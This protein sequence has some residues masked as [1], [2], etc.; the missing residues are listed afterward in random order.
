VLRR[1][2]APPSPRAISGDGF[3]LSLPFGF[4]LR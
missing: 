1:T 3:Q 4:L 2:E